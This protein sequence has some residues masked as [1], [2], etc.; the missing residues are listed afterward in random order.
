[1]KGFFRLSSKL[2]EVCL[3]PPYQHHSQSLRPVMESSM[4]GARALVDAGYNLGQ[5][6][7][8]GEPAGSSPSVYKRRRW[9]NWK[10]SAKADIAPI[11]TTDEYALDAM[12]DAI[13][14]LIHVREGWKERHTHSSF[15]VPIRLSTSAVFTAA[16]TPIGSAAIAVSNSTSGPSRGWI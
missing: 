7:I 8:I 9:R 2:S 3:T 4:S 6:A 1:M 15:A 14:A 16:T 5:A 13:G 12:Y 10:S 11:Q